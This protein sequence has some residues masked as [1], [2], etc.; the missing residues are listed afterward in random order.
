MRPGI[1]R[2]SLTGNDRL[3]IVVPMPMRA[4]AHARHADSPGIF[5]NVTIDGVPMAFTFTNGTWFHDTTGSRPISTSNATLVIS[6]PPNS[7]GQ[8]INVTIWG[9]S[10]GDADANGVFA[11]GDIVQGKYLYAGLFRT[12]SGFS[13]VKGYDQVDVNHDGMFTL[14]D[15]VKMKYYLAKLI[16][17]DF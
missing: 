4:L 1:T 6:V 10:L 16:G 13:E 7:N 3:Q 2:W 12:A 11:L 5:A 8:T 17:P 15:I 9:T 14:A